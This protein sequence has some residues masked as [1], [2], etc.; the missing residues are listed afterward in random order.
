MSSLPLRTL[1]YPTSDGKPMAETDVHRDLMVDLITELR[2]YYAGQRVYV[3]GNLLI[4]YERGNRRRHVAPDVFVVKEVEPRVRDNYLVWEEGRAPDVV[5]ELTSSTEEE[6]RT[7][8]MALYR[9]VLQVREYFLFDPR[10]DWLDPPLQGYRLVKGKYR[11]IRPRQGRLPSEELGLHLERQGNQLRL[12]NP[13]T[14]AWLPTPD[15]SRRQDR[16]ARE[17]AEE[18]AESAEERAESAEE[19]AE[20]EGQARAEAE[21]RAAAEARARKEVDA[22]LE[23]MRKELETLRRRSD[24]AK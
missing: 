16:L 12:W 24:E 2:T 13:R 3:S 7:T 17:S 18:R 10:G 8:K 6:D 5:I 1:P 23:R 4:C 20:Q 9:D 11:K 15:E 22:E 19:R 14:Q 21:R